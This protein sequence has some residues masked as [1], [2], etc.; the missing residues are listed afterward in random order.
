MNDLVSALAALGLVVSPALMKLAE[1]SSSAEVEPAR[2]CVA[3][4]DAAPVHVSFRGHGDIAARLDPGAEVHAV[5]QRDNWRRIVYTDGRRAE[6]GWVVGNRLGECSS[7]GDTAGADEDI[8]AMR[9]DEVDDLPSGAPLPGTFRVH[10]IDVGTGLA[11]LVQGSDFNLLFDGGSLDDRA[12][13]RNNRLLAYLRAAIG[14]A[15]DEACAPKGDDTADSAGAGATIDHLFLSHPHQDHAQLLD[16]V[17]RCYVVSNVWDVG[18]V[19]HAAFYR[20]FL[21]AVAA[22]PEVAYHTAVELPA[23]RTVIVADEAVAFGDVEWSR[24]ATD[25]ELALGREATLRV[26]HV[27]DEDRG[28]DYN[29]N[30]IVV[31]LDLGAHSLLL[32]GDEEAGDRQGHD[33]AEH[34]EAKLLQ[35]PELLD[36]DILQVPHHGSLTSNRA[37][38]LD[39]V[40]PT[41]ALIGD[42][43]KRFSGTDLPDHEV[44]ESLL[45]VLGTEHAL[46]AE[47]RLLNTNEHDVRGCPSDDRIGRD[48]PKNPGGCDNWMLEITSTEE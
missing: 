34:P 1:R 2:M 35:R 29:L 48:D 13:G 10:H 9:V 28:D 3:G 16:D 41:W 14:P 7:T 19:N 18:V 45:E 39:A 5:E 25:H 12:G 42:G 37:A 11:V 32:T 40:S 23:D 33:G 17:L 27:D 36:V 8:V 20:E 6:V 24:F 47:Q 31:R 38:F 22:E 44:V 4:D 15:E 21:A 43:P 46:A 30:S 26:L